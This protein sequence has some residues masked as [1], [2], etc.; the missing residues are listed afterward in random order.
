MAALD[1]PLR[2]GG[3]RLRNRLCRAP[4]LECAGNGPD[5]VQTFIDELEPVA[6]AHP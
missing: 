6:E 1:D 2:V 5:A 4:L 3:V